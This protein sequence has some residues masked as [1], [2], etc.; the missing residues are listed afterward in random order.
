MIFKEEKRF[1]DVPMP[2]KSSPKSRDGCMVGGI[3]M[4][5]DCGGKSTRSRYAYAVCGRASTSVYGAR[6]PVY[7]RAD[8]RLP[9]AAIKAATGLLSQGFLFEVFGVRFLGLY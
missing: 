3:A 5:R 1:N 7:R 2:E 6:A 8:V 9:V 4:Q